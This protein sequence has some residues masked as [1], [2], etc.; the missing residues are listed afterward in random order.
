MQGDCSLKKSLLIPILGN[1]KSSRPASTELLDY[2]SA[3]ESE[4]EALDVEKASQYACHHC[5]G[6]SEYLCF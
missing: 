3:S 6:S 4:M 5:Y 2:A 1:L